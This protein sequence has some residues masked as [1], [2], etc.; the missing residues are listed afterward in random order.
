MAINKELRD[1][2]TTTPKRGFNY[3]L[4]ENVTELFDVSEDKILL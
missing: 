3:E 2:L 4:V 1:N